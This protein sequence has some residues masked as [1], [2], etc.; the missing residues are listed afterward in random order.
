MGSGNKESAWMMNQSVCSIPRITLQT[1]KVSGIQ[2]SRLWEKLFESQSK[3]QD[4]RF[5]EALFE[6]QALSLDEGSLDSKSFI[7]I[8]NLEP[9]IGIKKVFLRILSLESRK[10]CKLCNVF[11]TQYFTFK[12]YLC[13][14]ILYG[15][16]NSYIKHHFGK[17][18]SNI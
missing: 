3:I 6:S 18:S 17:R 7:R 14:I 10:L 2:D 11:W 5:W 1:C 8:L 15:P 13:E 4:S 16:S 9:W 12:F